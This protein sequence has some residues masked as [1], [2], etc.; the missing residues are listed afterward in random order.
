M[1]LLRR[2]PG[3]SK[4]RAVEIAIREYLASDAALRTRSIA[5]KVRVE[6]MSKRMRSV[7]RTT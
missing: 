6:D 1:D 7:D 2:H 4:R 5:G 3:L